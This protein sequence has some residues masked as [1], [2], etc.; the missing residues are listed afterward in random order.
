M[1]R[2]LNETNKRQIPSTK[3]CIYVTADPVMN[4]RPL[5]ELATINAAKSGCSFSMSSWNS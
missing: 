3:P 5:R 4:T 1:Q 2:S